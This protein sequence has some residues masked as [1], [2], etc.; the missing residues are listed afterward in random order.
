VATDGLL[1]G[2]SAFAFGCIK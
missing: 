1:Y 2:R